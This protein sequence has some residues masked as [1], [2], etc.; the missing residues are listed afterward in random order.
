MY[1]FFDN[2][3]YTNTYATNE[4][5]VCP[6][7]LDYYN[8]SQN[9]YKNFRGENY[10]FEDTEEN[11][12]NRNIEKTEYEGLFRAWNPWTN[13]GG[14]ITSGLGASSWAANRIDLFA[15]GRGGELIHNWFDNGKWNYWENL[16][17]ILTS[18]PKAVSWGFNRIDVVCRGTDNAM[19]H[20]WWD[21]STW[22]GFENLGG[23]LTS[24]PTI[25]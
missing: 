7:F 11:I 13:L 3:N 6:Y 2:P 24:A 17:G 16:G 20:K 25:C 23:Q 21:G 4:D 5:F 19:Y 22:S 18:S 15:R 10:D 9:N 14:D 12:E 8:N 1:P